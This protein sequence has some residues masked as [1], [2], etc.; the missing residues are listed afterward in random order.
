MKISEHCYLISGLAVEP[1]WAVNAGF[2]VGENTTLI[3]D[4]GSNYLSAQTIYGYASSI[5]S[6]NQI[7]VVNTEPH[8]D[9]IGGNCFFGEKFIDIFAFPGS[10]RKPDEFRQNIEELNNTIANEVRRNNNEAEIFFYN[11]KLTNP[12]KQISHNDIIELGGAIVNVYHTPGHTP[13]NISLFVPEDRVLYCGDCIVTGYLPNLEAGNSS[14][15]KI[16]LNSLDQIQDLNPE[17]I[18]TGH[19]YYIK[20]SRNIEIEIEKTK[21][22]LKIAVNDDIAPTLKNLRLKKY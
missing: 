22:I 18:V 12:N 21:S 15:W 4:T 5:R 2:I 8:F 14:S 19:G 3:V 11:T 7:I 6:E 16:W 20:G 10:S 9:H 13:F 1:P 17:L